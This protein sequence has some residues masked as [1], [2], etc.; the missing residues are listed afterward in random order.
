VIYNGLLTVVQSTMCDGG[1]M[2]CTIH[3]SDSAQ[4]HENHFNKGSRSKIKRYHVKCYVDCHPP[5]EIV[6]NVNEI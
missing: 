6:L 4:A 3:Q 5:L 2:L 1:I